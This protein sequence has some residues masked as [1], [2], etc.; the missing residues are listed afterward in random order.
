MLCGCWGCRALPLLSIPVADLPAIRGHSDASAALARLKLFKVVLLRRGN[1]RSVTILDDLSVS[2][3]Q[4]ATMTCRTRSVRPIRPEHRS[5][6]LTL[7][8]HAI[9]TAVDTSRD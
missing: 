8:I 7:I 6:W 9:F 2:D 5:V 1:A 4:L 3:F